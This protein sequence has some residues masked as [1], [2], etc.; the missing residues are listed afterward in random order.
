M[1]ERAIDPGG[2]GGGGDESDK[3]QDGQSRRSGRSQSD[4]VT[5]QKQHEATPER[6][7]SSAAVPL[8]FVR[9]EVYCSGTFRELVISLV[10][11]VFY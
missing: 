6:N 5:L 8:Q 10:Y 2:G 1:A 11:V 3:R 7:C 9:T 4:Q